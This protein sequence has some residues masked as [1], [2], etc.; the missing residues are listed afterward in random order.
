MV[1]TKADLRASLPGCDLHTVVV[2]SQLCNICKCLV[3]REHHI[4]TSYL[5][6]QLLG[7]E[8]WKRSTRLGKPDWELVGACKYIKKKTCLTIGYIGLEFTMCQYCVSKYSRYSAIVYAA[9]CP[10]GT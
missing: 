7:F 10:Q 8:T 4:S 2:K 6:L 1:V 9:F 5:L 3:F